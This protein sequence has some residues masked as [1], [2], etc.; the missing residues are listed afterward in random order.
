MKSIALLLLATICISAFASHRINFNDYP[1]Q[2]SGFHY[3]MNR[4]SG[5]VLE[6]K[7]CG[8]DRSEIVQQIA[9]AEKEQFWQARFV[10]KNGKTL[11]WLFVNAESGNLLAVPETCKVNHENIPLIQVSLKSCKAEANTQWLISGDL[12]EWKRMRN[13]GENGMYAAIKGDSYASGALAVTQCYRK[14]NFL[15]Q[16]WN[17]VEV[18]YKA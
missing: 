7:N 15:S 18:P 5:K 12:G 17:F 13:R 14:T 10:K 2:S 1:G 6:P 3:I 16:L 4:R 11:Y 8:N 9:N